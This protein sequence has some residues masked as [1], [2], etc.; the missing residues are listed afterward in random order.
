[1]HQAGH[2]GGASP[3]LP[4]VGAA[5]GA[6]HR[7]KVQKARAQNRAGGA[8][9]DGRNPAAGS[10]RL[11]GRAGSPRPPLRAPASVSREGRAWLL[12]AGREGLRGI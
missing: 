12:R 9:G 8:A 1:M 6:F 4:R 11:P 3:L 10:A 5:G 7:R 2:R